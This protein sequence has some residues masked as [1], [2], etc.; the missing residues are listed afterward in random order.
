MLKID[1][2]FVRDISTDPGDKAIVS[3]VI[4]MAASLGLQTIAEGVETARQMD[5]LREQGC[6][7]VQG[8]HCSRPLTAEHFAAFLKEREAVPGP[9]PLAPAPKTQTGQAI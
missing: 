7:Q 6:D 9:A 8:Y 4:R 1:Q 5:F 3:A 2:S